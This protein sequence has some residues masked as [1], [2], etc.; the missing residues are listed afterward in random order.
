MLRQSRMALFV[1]AS[2][3]TPAVAQDELESLIRNAIEKNPVVQERWHQFLASDKAVEGAYSGYKPSVDVGARYGHEWRDYGPR[4]DFAGADAQITLTQMLYDGFETRNDVRRLSSLQ[5]VRYH[6]LLN[7]VEQ[8]AF[9]AF[10]AY[11]DV[12]RRR[13]LLEFAQQNLERH[14]EVFQQIIDGVAAGVVRTADLE[15]VSG[16]VALAESNVVTE[17]SNLHDVTA[18]FL[19]IIGKVP[20]LDAEPYTP[21]SNALPKSLEAL[22][23][24]A[25]ENNPAFH[26]AIRNIHAADSTVDLR[27]SAMQPRLNLTANYGT[28]TYDDFGANSGRSDA[29]IGVELRYNL[30]RGG[31]DRAAI[32][33]AYQQ[34]NVAKNLRDQ[35]CINL[36]QNVQIAHH[37]IHA[38]KRQLPSLNQHR[39]SSERVVVAYRD[40]FSIGERTLLDVLDAENEAFQAKSAYANAQHDKNIAMAR[41]LTATGDWLATVGVIRDGLPT[42]TDLGASPLP[43]DGATACPSM[44][45]YVIDSDGDGVP[46]NLDFCPGTPRGAIV[47]ARGCKRD[48]EPERT[49][50]ADIGFPVGSAQIASTYEPDLAEIADFI[51]SNNDAKVVIEGHASRVGSASFNQ[52]LSELRAEAAARLLTS[53]FGVPRQRLDVVGYGFD[54]PRVE[55]DTKAAHEANQ[56]I[57]IRIFP[58]QTNIEN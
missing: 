38:I 14:Q 56:R 34:T 9:E 7:I 55:G 54:R 23:H 41:A 44:A 50:E 6:E 30:Y 39:L 47:D 1:A 10:Q 13:E 3:S 42:L 31:R 15:Q 20:S 45:D 48:E 11:T 43:I 18:R 16:R 12:L 46:D 19:R 2:F 22:L 32:K 5:L 28:Q 36:R 17:Q 58:N 35:E 27:K 29:R 49:F 52:T 40:Q 8:T 37:N 24:R 26:A 53:Q 33:E 51:L 25:Y 21:D 57:E 4:D